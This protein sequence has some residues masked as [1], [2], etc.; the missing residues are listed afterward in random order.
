MGLDGDGDPP[1]G[2]TEEGEDNGDVSMDIE[3]T[4]DEFLKILEKNSGSTSLQKEAARSARTSSGTTT[5]TATAGIAEGMERW[6]LKKDSSTRR[7]E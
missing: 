7:Q 4:T 1:A 6:Q 3:E 5:A 2:R